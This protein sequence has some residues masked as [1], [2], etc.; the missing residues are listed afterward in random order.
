M[1]RLAPKGREGEMFGLYQT[2]GEAGSYI[3]PALWV[4]A[5]SIAGAF[6][7]KHTTIF[8]ILAI[9]LVLAVGLFLLL[10]VDKKKS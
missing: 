3:A 2:T 4:A 6:G 10:R 1:A 5:L 8:G 9:V 7:V